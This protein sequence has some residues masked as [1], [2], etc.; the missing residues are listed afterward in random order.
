MSAGRSSVIKVKL[1][2]HTVIPLY[3]L[4]TVASTRS[5]AAGVPMIR[6]TPRTSGRGGSSGCRQM[7]IPASSATGTT[8]RRK[9]SHGP[10]ARAGHQGVPARA[11]QADPRR[12]R[13]DVHAQVDPVHG[14]SAPPRPAQR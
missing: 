5:K 7:R 1:P 6:G 3:A 9:Y 2:W 10:V 4:G 11:D 14:V 13:A 8:S 12:R